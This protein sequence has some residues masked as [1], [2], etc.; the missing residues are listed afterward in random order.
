MVTLYAPTKESQL[1]YKDH[2]KWSG[3][4]KDRIYGGNMHIL[5]V[6]QRVYYH[7]G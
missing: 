3:R 1:A 5:I 4:F 6:K 2:E 7:P